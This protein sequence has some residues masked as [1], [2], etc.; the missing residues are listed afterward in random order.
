MDRQSKKKIRKERRKWKAEGRGEG[1]RSSDRCVALVSSGHRRLRPDVLQD[2]A[3]PPDSLE[4]LSQ[5]SRDCHSPREPPSPRSAPSVACLPAS[6][7]ALASSPPSP[8]CQPTAT[9]LERA[10]DFAGSP[11]FAVGGA[12]RKL[13]RFCWPNLFSENLNFLRDTISSYLEIF[14]RF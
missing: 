1:R 7:P 12:L 2:V 3:N 10:T 4:S 13:L 5:S 8:Q 6:A 14:T 9:L 11:P